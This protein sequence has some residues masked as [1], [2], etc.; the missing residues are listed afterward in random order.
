MPL[1]LG[2]MEDIVNA[3]EPSPE[4]QSVGSLPYALHHPERSYKPSSELPSAIQMKS[5]RGEQ[6]FFSHQMFLHS[7]VLIE[8]ALY[9]SL[10]LASDD[11]WRPGLAAKCAE[12]S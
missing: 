6:H 12:R 10:E 11:P 2:H 1:K 9:G 5:L 4:V 7:V 8:V 3:L